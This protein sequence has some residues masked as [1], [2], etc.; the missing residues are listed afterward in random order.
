MSL[1]ATS[2]IQFL[3]ASNRSC[4]SAK[5]SATGLRPLLMIVLMLL[6]N[7]VI[8]LAVPEHSGYTVS[9]VIDASIVPVK[10]DQIPLRSPL[11]SSSLN[12]SL[13]ALVVP[14]AF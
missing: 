11:V 4:A 13:P 5:R 3:L 2:A 14:V 9:V 12:S 7:V 6:K 10:P 1:T 8:A